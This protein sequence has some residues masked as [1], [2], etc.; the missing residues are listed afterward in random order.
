MVTA[1]GF[2]LSLDKNALVAQLRQTK[3]RLDAMENMRP[4][5]AEFSDELASARAA[6]QALQSRLQA[7]QGR[8]S[9]HLLIGV[10]AALGVVL[11]SSIA[12]TYFIGTSR[13]CR[14]VVEAYALETE[15]ITASQKLKRQSFPWAVVAMLTVV[16]VTA[17]G[18][19]SDPGTGN[20]N[21]ATWVT[22]HLLAALGGVALVCLCFFLLWTN[23]GANHVII[24]KVLRRVEEIRTAR[25]LKS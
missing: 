1:L 23:I 5:D 16:A 14:E 21:S 2:G 8:A 10:A 24:E 15:L 7:E 20:L 13:W 3:R 11:V 12:V 9:V 17:L 6:Y 22:P 18:A 4:V 19:A 25:G